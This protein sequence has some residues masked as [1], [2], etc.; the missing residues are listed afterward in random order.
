GYARVDWLSPVNLPVYGD[1]RCT[2][3][4]TEGYIELRKNIDLEGRTGGNHIFMVDKLNTRHIQC[5]D[6][7]L[8]FG[9]F[10]LHD[11]EQRTESAMPQQHCFLAS[12]LALKAQVLADLR[13]E[14]K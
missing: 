12:E 13:N 14:R 5:D 2:I 1:T 4:G 3:L 10:F 7:E 11:V 9:R 8:P 6:V